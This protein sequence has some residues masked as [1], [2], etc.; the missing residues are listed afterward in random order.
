MTSPSPYSQARFVKWTY[1]SWSWVFIVALLIFNGIL[2]IL[3]ALDFLEV[4]FR[5]P[6][7]PLI[8]SGIQFLCF[9]LLWVF[10]VFYFFWEQLLEDRSGAVVV[11]TAGTLTNLLAFILFLIWAIN[12]NTTSKLSFD[13]DPRAFTQ[14]ANANVAAFAMYMIL[15]G[16]SLVAAGQMLVWEKTL[17]LADYV[18]RSPGSE[19]L[20]TV[21]RNAARSRR[22]RQSPED[23]VELD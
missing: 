14:Y 13:D 8:W 22:R 5:A 20:R 3:Y 2:A 1:P 15:L 11:T 18:A 12:N 19:T 16:V 21:L 23:D 6:L 9:G 17:I 7:V 4:G 10:V